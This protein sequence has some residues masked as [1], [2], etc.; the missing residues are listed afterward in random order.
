MDK[1]MEEEDLKGLEEEIDEAVNRLFVEKKGGGAERFS[2][3]SEISQPPLKSPV[4]EPAMRDPTL[5]PSMASPILEIDDAVDRLFVEK[6]GEGVESLLLEPEPPGA[7]LKSPILVP[8][9]EPPT[10]EPLAKSPILETPVTPSFLE[11]SQE[12]AKTFE[13]ETP[14][15]PSSPPVPFLKSIEQMEAQLL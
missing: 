6:K 1:L 15:R 14:I 5:E 13:R 2:M 10:L 11:P 9:M 7:A 4:L 12:T 8:I 3:D